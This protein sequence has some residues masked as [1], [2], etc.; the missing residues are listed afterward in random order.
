MDQ[1]HAL[2]KK[3][4]RRAAGEETRRL[5]ECELA[6]TPREREIA[7]MP[8]P[9]R[10]RESS[11]Y[12][13][14]A[15]ASLLLVCG[16]AILTVGVRHLVGTARRPSEWVGAAGVAMKL[17]RIFVNGRPTSNLMAAGVVVRQ[18]INLDAWI[19]PDADQT[20]PV[21]VSLI[22]AH[23]PYI[24]S[25]TAAGFV[26]STSALSEESVAILCAFA[27]DGATDQLHVAGESITGPCADTR[28][29]PQFWENVTGKTYYC[30][31]L[32][33]SR[34]GNESCPPDRIVYAADQLGE[35]MLAHVAR[36]EWLA[37][38]AASSEEDGGV[39]YQAHVSDSV[40][41]GWTRH[42]TPPLTPAT[43][44]YCRYNELLLS[45]RRYAAV[46]PRLVEAVFYPTNCEAPPERNT[47][48]INE[49]SKA[50]AVELR[51]QL[52]RNFQL[53]PTQTPP[54]LSYDCGEA[55]AG[56]PPFQAGNN[57]VAMPFSGSA[58]LSFTPPQQSP[59]HVTP[60]PSPAAPLTAPPTM[61]PPLPTP[62]PPLPKPS[63]PYP[64]AS[65]IAIG[66]WGKEKGARI[67]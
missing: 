45:A 6:E 14:L 48:T 62:S 58:P 17:N 59:E 36:L 21:S 34:R 16:L 56:R 30:S 46:F 50:V 40:A 31:S 8:L 25:S 23:L 3:T 47:S 9:L 11:G 55:R 33:A 38:A 22:N 57:E 43:R 66:D 13:R 42:V 67:A 63:P 54:L 29:V 1:L 7:E 15:W 20:Q 27:I 35:M 4:A 39:E 52:R 26:L 28:I 32:E 12:T 53:S 19:A 61:P 51:S 49:G 60:Q 18:F 37:S 24:F 10:R 65:F 5:T 41:C 2:H 44:N 64:V